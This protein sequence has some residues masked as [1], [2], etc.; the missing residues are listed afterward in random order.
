MVVD[1]EAGV[2]KDAALGQ[3]QARDDAEGPY[4]DQPARGV[5]V[6]K[7]FSER[8]RHASS[9]LPNLRLESYA[10]H[11]TFQNRGSA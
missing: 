10:I 8:M 5:M 7:D 4:A 3:D 2:A 1:L 6:A 11:F 9:A